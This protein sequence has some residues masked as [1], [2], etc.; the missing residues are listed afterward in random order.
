MKSVLKALM[1]LNGLAFILGLV[2]VFFPNQNLFWN[3]FGILLLVTLTANSLVSILSKQHKKMTTSYLVLS[4]FGLLVV[5]GLNTLTSLWPT[6]TLSRSI[7]SIILLQATLLFG[8]FVC[9]TVLIDKQKINFYHS[10]IT[11]KNSRKS[12]KVKYRILMTVLGLL[13]GL[14]M[15]MAFFMLVPIPISIAE[16]I[17]SQYSLFYSLI[18]LSL[19]GLILKVSHLKRGSWQWYWILSI[20]VSLYILFSIPLLTLPTMLSD[21]EESYTNAFGENWQDLE[22]DYPLFRESP[23]SLP[24]YFYGIRSTD[25]NF[26]E[27]VLYYEGTEGVDEDLELR[28]DVYTPP[29][30]ASELP[31]NGAVL[32]RIHGGGWSTGGR[33]AQ[34]FAQFNKYFATQG[35]VVFDVEYGL[36]NDDD[37]SEFSQVAEAV[38]GEFSVDDMVR[39][40]GLFTTYLADNHEEYDADIDSVFF[41]GGSAG[42]HLAN[43]VGLG[44]ASGEYTDILDDRLTISGLIPLYPANGLASYRNLDGEEALVNPELLVDENSPPALVYQGDMD[45]IVDPR[46]AEYFRDSYLDNGNTDF[47]LIRAPY[48]EHVSDLYFPG[49]YSQM[50]VYYMERFMVENR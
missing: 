28:F 36:N 1:G 38:T 47:A 25:Y 30:D 18:F 20:G 42:G 15:L 22:N 9:R 37:L 13:L 34:N 21:A 16:V 12:S 23:L 50:F 45:R 31:G 26:T 17:L 32:I 4:S 5:M 49:Y 7:L 43:A 35:Y 8:L 19:A 14:G 11:F 27:G 39:H 10:Q 33:G 6:Y 2:Y 40:L 48:G 44:I 24:D 3:G 29:T 46:V 41:S